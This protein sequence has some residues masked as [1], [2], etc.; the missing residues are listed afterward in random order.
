VPPTNWSKVGISAP[1]AKTV[2]MKL[3]RPNPYALQLLNYYYISPLHKPSF[4]AHGNDFIQPANFVGNGAYVIKELVPQS[5][6][7]LVKNPNYWDAANVA[8][9]SIKY[10]VT[11]DVNTELKMFKAGQLD[12][13]WDVPTDQLAALKV[14]FGDG[15]RV[16]PYASTGHLTFNTQKEP[17]SDIRIRKALA[18]AIDRDIVVNKIAKSGDPIITAF[19]RRPEGE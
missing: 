13:T 7:L 14:E 17:L 15:L 6:V 12:I 16:A 3:D 18:L 10:V 4:D 5:H 9:E 2:V 11:E 1:D 8:V 19:Q